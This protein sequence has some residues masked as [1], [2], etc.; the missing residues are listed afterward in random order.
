MCY[1]AVDRH[2]DEGMGSHTAIIHD[3]PVTGG[4]LKFTYKELQDEVIITAEF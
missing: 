2:V 3:S 1:N 4:V